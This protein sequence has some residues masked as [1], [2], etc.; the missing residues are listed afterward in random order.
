MDPFNSDIEDTD[1]QE[2][3]G[4]LTLKYLLDQFTQSIRLELQLVNLGNQ[5]TKLVYN[6]KVKSNATT[7]GA[8]EAVSRLDEF[9]Q[10]IC[11]VA[12]QGA[13]RVKLKEEYVLHFITVLKIRSSPL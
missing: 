2:N 12:G 5:A 3:Q 11:L 8:L 10:T 1:L 7:A 13:D 6:L 4:S 9:I